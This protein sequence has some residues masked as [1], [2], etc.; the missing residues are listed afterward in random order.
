MLQILSFQIKEV[1]LCI[2][3]IPLPISSMQIQKRTYLIRLKIGGCFLRHLINCEI[4]E[5]Q[6]I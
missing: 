5:Q 3:H 1:L 2:W 4:R 6:K